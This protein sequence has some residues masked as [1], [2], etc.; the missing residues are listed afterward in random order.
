MAK[1]LNYLEKNPAQKTT[2]FENLMIHLQGAENRFN[3]A[4]HDYN[5]LCSKYDRA[6]LIFTLKVP[7]PKVVF[8]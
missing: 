7:A 5:E 1:I 4:R 8:D 6:D 2:D 3:V